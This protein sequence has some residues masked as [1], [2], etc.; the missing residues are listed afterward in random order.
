MVHVV[1]LRAGLDEVFDLLDWA[2]DRSRD[3]IDI[4]RLHD[5]LQVIFQ[6]LG[7]VIYES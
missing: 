2:F 7:E 6:D 1:H 5:G 4:L 3:L